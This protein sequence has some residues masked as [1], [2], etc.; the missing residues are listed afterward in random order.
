MAYNLYCWRC[1]TVVPMLDEI[2]WGLIE[3]LLSEG[4]SELK[5]YRQAHEASLADAGGK[6]FGQAALKIY[7]TLT[8]F[9]EENVNVILHHRISLYG[10]PCNSCG[11][12]L[13]T[14]QASFCA[15]C[16]VAR[17]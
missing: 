14:P 13:R 3:P 2:E 7:R 1:D 6:V 11:K 5:H 10:P 8:G 4:L 12:P 17:D 15:A 16:G 9:N